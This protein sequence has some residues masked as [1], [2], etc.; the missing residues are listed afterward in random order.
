MAES[1]PYETWL[2]VDLAWLRKQRG[3][4]PTRV[5]L[6]DTLQARTHMGLQEA[7]EIVEDFGQRHGI[8]EAWPQD[9]RREPSWGWTLAL[10]LLFLASS[11]F[12]L[13]CEASRRDHHDIL[14]VVGATGSAVLAIGH[15][16]STV[17][18]RRKQ[19]RDKGR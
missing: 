7:T 19:R 4:D 5:M 14:M 12:V 17:L 18:R 11:V 16:V 15:I 3:C 1:R 13:G 6:M 2:E 10:D 9:D 8:A